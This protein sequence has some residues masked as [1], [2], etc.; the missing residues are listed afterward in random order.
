LRRWL[1]VGLIQPVAIRCSLAYF[2]FHQIAFIKQLQGLLEGGTSLAQIRRGIEQTRSLLPPGASIDGLVA[3]LERDGRVLLRLRERLVDQM[4]Q[5]YFEFEPANGGASTVFVDAMQHAIHDLC[6]DALALEE[7]GSLDEAS[8][9]Y[10]RAL[11]LQPDHPT[12]HF[13]LGNVL[14]QLGRHDEALAAFRHAT[15]LDTE[16][17]MAW[18]NLGSVHA[19]QRAWDEAEAALR[20]ALELVPTYADSHFTLAQVL[21]IQGRQQDAATHERAYHVHSKA[22]C[23]LATRQ[24]HL[25]VVHVDNEDRVIS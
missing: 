19:Q 2:D 8:Q 20:R 13:D 22:E 15:R 3:N 24:S 25:R 12:L 14:F 16:F 18:H 6:D 1:G 23:L 5:Q 11:Q 17:A 9:T 7:A 10:E 4:G 21:R